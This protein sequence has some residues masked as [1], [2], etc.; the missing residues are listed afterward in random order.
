MFAIF[1]FVLGLICWI[2]K[3]SLPKI[4]LQLDRI[5]NT[6]NSFEELPSQVQKLSEEVRYCDKTS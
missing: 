4:F 1:T 3:T 5:S 6:M 2:L